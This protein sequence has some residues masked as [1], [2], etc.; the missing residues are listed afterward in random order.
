[1][2]QNIFNSILTKKPKRNKFDLSHDVKMSCKLGELVPIMCIP[3]VP[4][5]TFNIG[6][7][8]LVRFAPLIA[9]IMHRVDATIHYFYV[10]NRILWP[11]F[12]KFIIG[13][14]NPVTGLEYEHPK[15]FHNLTEAR[16]ADYLGLPANPGEGFN[17]SAL[18]FAAYQAVYNEYY[19]DQNLVPNVEFQLEDGQQTLGKAISLIQLRMRAWEHDYFTAALPFAQKGDEVVLPMGNFNDVPI[20][21]NSPSVGVTEW[22]GEPSAPWKVNVDNADYGPAVRQGQLIAETSGLEAGSASINNLRRAFRLQEWLEKNA[23]GGTRPWEVLLNHFGVRS[24]DSRLQRPEY[25][26]GVKS[27]VVVSEVVNTTGANDGLPQGNMSGHA[28][29]VVQGGNKGFFCPEHGYIIG[30]M[31]VMAKTAYQD[32]VDKDWT[33]FDRTEYYWP[34]FAHIGEQEVKNREVHVSHI[35]PEGTFG[36]VPR[37]AEYKFCQNRVAGDFR[38][39]LAFWHFGRQLPTNVAL[40]R[41][42]IEAKHRTDVFAVEDEINQ[43]LWCQVYNRVSAIRPMPVFGTPQI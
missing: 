5:D 34:S 17:I 9:P 20:N 6:A 1:M 3:T 29:S 28:V 13:E 42:F 8:A 40:N 23:R 26:T 27:P 10:P 43:H 25:I 7:D 22:N 33:K 12:S 41:A 19:R 15:I 21:L 14:K 2:K 11:N 31:S 32:G 38:N 35:N 4:G 18:P 30:I 36:Y 39:S 24:Q 16:L 37:Y